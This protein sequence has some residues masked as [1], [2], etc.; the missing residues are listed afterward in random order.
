[1]TMAEE[2]RRDMHAV[3]SG[4]ARWR[5]V[6]MQRT[7]Y[8]INNAIIIKMSG[9]GSFLFLAPI[10]QIVHLALACCLPFYY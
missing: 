3:E 8:S 7:S 1:M 2:T 4:I 5:L 6:G 9:S 10:F